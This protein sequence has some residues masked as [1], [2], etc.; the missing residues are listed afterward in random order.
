MLIGLVMS[1]AG[2]I[3]GKIV[4]DLLNNKLCAIMND[5]LFTYHGMRILKKNI[6]LKQ[7]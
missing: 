7:H 2:C 6:Q 4:H 1:G 3:D 5:N